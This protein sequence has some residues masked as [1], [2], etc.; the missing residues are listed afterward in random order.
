MI[1]LTHNGMT[2][3]FFNNET[4]ALS[5]MQ[6]QIEKGLNSKLLVEQTETDEN[7]VIIR[8]VIVY[9]YRTLYSE[10]FLLEYMN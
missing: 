10:M 2:V 7:G 6:E 3:K 8:K 4:V 5:Y 9:Q 1:R